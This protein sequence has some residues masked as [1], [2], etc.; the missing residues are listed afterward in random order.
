MG[1]SGVGILKKPLNQLTNPIYNDIRKGAPQFK[2]SGKSWKVDTG[3]TMLET[4]HT[5]FVYD[6]GVL[7]QSRDY[8][9]QTSYGRSSHK[10]VVNENFRPPLI[11]LEDV[12]PLSR[13]P[14]PLAYVRLN[15]GTA[16]SHGG[17]GSA[18]QDN[19]SFNTNY[20]GKLLGNDKV[21]QV[22][23][24]PTFY[25][26]LD[27]PADNSV[28]PDLEMKLPAV[29]VSSGFNGP[30]FDAPTRPV[31]LGGGQLTPSRHAGF[32]P[33]FSTAGHH[34]SETPIL[35]DHHPSVSVSSGHSVPYT[36]GM[37]PIDYDL[38]EH[39]LQVSV[40]A[41]H[42]PSFRTGVTPID[43]FDKVKEYNP[44]VSAS[45]GTNS[46]FRAGVTPIDYDLDE[47][48]PQVSVTAGHNSSYRSGTTPIDY[49]L[50]YTNPQVSAHAGY[51]SSYK[52][53]LTPIERHLDY[54]NPQV[55]AHA[56]SSSLYREG[57][58]PVDYHLDNKTTPISVG[59][60]MNTP[61]QS[62]MEG[63]NED[64]RGDK[65]HPAVFI[66]PENSFRS[67]NGRMAE[68]S[69]KYSDHQDISYVPPAE[70]PFKTRN[71]STHRPGVQQKV[72]GSA[73]A[74]RGVKGQG[75][76]PR[77]GIAIAPANLRDR[78]KLVVAE[79]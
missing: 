61:M 4:E 41:G 30:A 10:D 13:L 76:I 26:P 68:G 58:R 71:V 44:Q 28:L 14:H 57:I 63:K 48:H 47:H 51:K 69:I 56:G 45:A 12:L 31:E 74:I 15:P 33:S 78:T 27:M 36:S 62:K 1:S 40:S 65:I 20:K 2:W 35:E 72:P 9:K 46:S 3:K 77:A 54:T 6:Y 11:T 55:S 42:D 29:S 59:S 37:T 34:Q 16:T 19:Q 7:I 38:D 5:P 66:R 70:S 18:I 67:T 73:A 32:N 50:D 8:N 21:T 39:H 60:G 53:G 49:D 43:H 64:P 17:F 79:V 22:G 52:A 75:Y 23:I 25:C 24:R